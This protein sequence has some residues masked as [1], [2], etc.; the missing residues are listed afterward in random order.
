MRL[1]LHQLTRS[2]CTHPSNSQKPEKA[3]IFFARKL[4]AKT[5]KTINICLKLIHFGISSTL[6][7]FDREYYEYH[8]RQRE[9]QWLEIGGYKSAFLVDL[10][11]SY[12]FERAKAFFHPTIYHQIYRDDGVVVFNGKRNA[13]NIR[14]WLE[15]FQKTV[16]KSA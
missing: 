11:E 7:Y 12:L 8:S 15:E 16:N 2:I 3:V 9:E 10:V 1:Q 4:T 5:K 13:S 6:I 14:D